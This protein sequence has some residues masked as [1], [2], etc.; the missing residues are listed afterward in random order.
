MRVYIDL[1]STGGFGEEVVVDEVVVQELVFLF[2]D[3]LGGQDKY[4][5]GVS[6]GHSGRGAGTSGRS[7]QGN[8]GDGG[9]EDGGFEGVNLDVVGCNVGRW[10]PKVSCS[11]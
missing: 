1:F 3:R 2:D 6:D 9:V 7:R 8:S 4:G 5:G 10:W 11:G